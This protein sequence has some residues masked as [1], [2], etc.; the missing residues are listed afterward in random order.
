MIII[1]N[2]YMITVY[3]SQ[4]SPVHSYGR[5]DLLHADS[6]HLDTGIQLKIAGRADDQL[7]AVGIGAWAVIN[8]RI[9]GKSS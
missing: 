8:D 9:A 1:I 2:V 6:K 5:E 3:S 4:E 7:T